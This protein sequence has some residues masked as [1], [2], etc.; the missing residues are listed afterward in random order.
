[1]FTCNDNVRPALAKIQNKNGFIYAT[2]AHVLAKV[3]EEVFVK[4]YETHN[5]YPDA[6]RIIQE[7]QSV[8]KK[9]VSVN[10]LFNDLMTIEVCFKPKL[11]G[12]SN[13][14]GEGMVHC[15]CCDYTNTCRECRGE[16]VVPGPELELSGESNCK[17]FNRTYKLA[18]IDK[19]IRTAVTLGVKKIEISNGEAPSSIF[20]VGDFKILIMIVAER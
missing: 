6:D 7:H 18:A 15:D 13:C 5:N 3:P 16:G 19:I 17:V 20:T 1:M 14:S 2:D 12:C 10:Q 8:E 4:K 9:T 11:I